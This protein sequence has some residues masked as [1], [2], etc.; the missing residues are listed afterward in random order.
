ML[1]EQQFWKDEVCLSWRWDDRGE[2]VSSR[3][4]NQ[5]IKQ[6]CKHVSAELWTVALKIFFTK[7]WEGKKMSLIMKS[8]I[9]NLL[10]LMSLLEIS[11]A[12][13][14]RM[15]RSVRVI[16]DICSI[17]PCHCVLLL[18]VIKYVV[19][20]QLTSLTMEAFLIKPGILL[21]LASIQSSTVWRVNHYQQHSYTSTHIYTHTQTST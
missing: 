17:Q 10:L 7:R 15:K 3:M 6:I 18:W 11:R 19:T 21:Y 5:P 20:A 2:L 13:H 1:Q 8:I 16:T 14:Q 9:I 4:G 12:D